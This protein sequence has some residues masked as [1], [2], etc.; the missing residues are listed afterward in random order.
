MP[1][2][3]RLTRNSLIDIANGRFTEIRSNSYNDRNKILKILFARGAEHFG[4]SPA[5]NRIKASTGFELDEADVK[6]DTSFGQYM[7]DSPELKSLEEFRSELEIAHHALVKRI[8]ETDELTTEEA[9]KW[10]NEFYTGFS[11]ARDAVLNI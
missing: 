4:L 2:L 6:P 3:A 11:K 1:K 5:I 9:L 8:K 7:F 10:I